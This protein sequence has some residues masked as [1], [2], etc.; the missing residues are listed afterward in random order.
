M[1]AGFRLATSKEEKL[2]M[3]N[4]DFDIP[5]DCRFHHHLYYKFLKKNFG[6]PKSLSW[7]RRIELEKKKK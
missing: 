2:P 7:P 6:K 5:N 3:Y 1:L 4:Y